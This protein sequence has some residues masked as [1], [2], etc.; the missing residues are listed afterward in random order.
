LNVFQ[1]P[2]ITYSI[3]YFLRQGDRVEVTHHQGIGPILSEPAVVKGVLMLAIYEPVE[4]LSRP[5]LEVTMVT[6]LTMAE[7]TSLL[8]NIQVQCKSGSMKIRFNGRKRQPVKLRGN[9]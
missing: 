1:G 8:G 2:A 4:R 9:L 6:A 7:A 3:N 5:D